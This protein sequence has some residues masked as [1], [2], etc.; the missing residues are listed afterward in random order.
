MGCYMLRVLLKSTPPAKA[1]ALLIVKVVNSHPLN[2]AGFFRR[3][4]MVIWGPQADRL[5]L[6]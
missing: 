5:R 2:S 4:Y 3:T 6:S 1:G